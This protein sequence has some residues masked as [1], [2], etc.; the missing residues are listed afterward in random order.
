MSLVIKMTDLLYCCNL[1]IGLILLL[2]RL[3]FDGRTAF[4]NCNVVT[5]A[6]VVDSVFISKCSFPRKIFLDLLDGVGGALV[7]LVKDLVDIT[8]SVESTPGAA[9]DGL[10]SL[11]DNSGRPFRT[12]PTGVLAR[13]E[14]VFVFWVRLS[15]EHLAEQ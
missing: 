8:Q 14:D 15:L 2:L 7:P 12:F 11:D 4:D 10:F 13:K 9:V 1:Y 6:D 3:V 5:S